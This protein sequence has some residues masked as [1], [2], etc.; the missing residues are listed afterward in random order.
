MNEFSS[1]DL[2]DPGTID[3]IVNARHGDP[4][5]VL[6]PHPVPGGIVIRTLQPDAQSVSVLERATDDVICTL[7]RIHPAGLFSGV[8][9]TAAPYKL[10]VD[11]GELVRESEDPYS[12]PLLL[13]DLDIHLLAEGRHHD[14]GRCLGAHPMRINGV[15]GVRFAVWAPNARRVSVVGDFNGWDGRCYP[16]RKRVEAGVWELFIPR[17]APGALYKYE[18]LG[19]WGEMLPLKADPVAWAAEAPPK[20]ASIVVRT[21]AVPLRRRR[22]ARAR[23]GTQ[24]AVGADLGL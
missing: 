16:M 15:Q 8:M 10:R 18:L 9:Q 5:A 14:F 19:P 3:A 21:R 23:G 6:G 7:R 1:Q 22:L 17:L 20:T 12:F 11:T 2:P 4:F 13:G 24:R